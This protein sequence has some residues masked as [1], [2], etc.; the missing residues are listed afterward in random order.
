MTKH[1]R[2]TVRPLCTLALLLTVGLAHGEGDRSAAAQSL[3]DEGRR[4][5]DAGRYEEACPKLE[6]SQRLDPAGG[7]LLNLAAC[8]DAIG[9]T[10]SSWASY[11]EALGVAAHDGREDR[12]EEALA[13]ISALEAKLS[14]LRIDVDPRNPRDLEIRYGDHEIGAAAWG[15]PVAVDPG[16]YVVVARAMH[17][18]EWSAVVEVGPDA[19]VRK[20]AV[21]LLDEL[22]IVPRPPSPTGVAHSMTG[23]PRVR[24]APRS[25]N[26]ARTVGTYAAF[27]VGVAGLGVGTYYGIRA[28]SKKT[29]SDE[30]CAGNVCPANEAGAV[31][32]NGDAQR[33]AWI[34]DVALGVGL[35]AT[36]VG[37]YLWLT[38][39]A[40]SAART[41]IG[42]A[43]SASIGSRLVL[44]R[45]W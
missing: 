19:G 9:R 39:P 2:S 41:R 35:V 33:S 43:P 45:T 31:E 5:M 12:V 13:R 40:R 7:T 29:S 10:A 15:V 26:A 1:A 30:L 22:P 14:K 25:T 38:D 20:V 21:P 8:Y 16:K 44:E 34:C 36:G 6:E 17:R 24:E 4:L 27:T 37:V 18:K 32:L 3:F 28:L 42:L 11:K 23:A